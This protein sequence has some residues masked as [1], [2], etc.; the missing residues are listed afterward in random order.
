MIDSE[1]GR[2]RLGACARRSA[3]AVNGTKATSLTAIHVGHAARRM[4]SPAAPPFGINH[5]AAALLSP[6]RRLDE[7][8]RDAAGDRELPVAPGAQGSPLLEGTISG[9]DAASVRA[10]REAGAVILG[11]TTTTEFGLLSCIS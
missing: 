9:R 5:L 1:C 3:A 11:K 2:H 4:P 6:H 7:E 8:D 10:L